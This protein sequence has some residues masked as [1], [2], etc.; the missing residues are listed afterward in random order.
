MAVADE[1]RERCDGCGRTVSLETLT[2]VAMPG[3]EH[4]ACCP[5]CEPHARAAARRSDSLDQR[6]GS[7]DGC[8]A[9]V[10]RDRLEDAVL[11]DGTVV[12]CCPSCLEEVPGASETGT[13]GA[14]GDGRRAADGRK[15][16]CS[17]CREWVFTERFRVRLVDGRTEKL[18]GDCKTA[19]ER[20]GVIT[21]V[22]MRAGEARDVL[23]VDADASDEEI[24]EA[25]HREVK[26]AHPDRKSGSRAAFSLVTEAYDRLTEP[27]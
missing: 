26:S 14:S 9:D 22:K 27:R 11:P 12:S 13:D 25:F 5:T 7:C 21:D 18:C 8:T 24:R 1:R 3:G 10:L 6:R 19:A 4:V 20:D 15:R 17:Q 2:A 23:G 16:L